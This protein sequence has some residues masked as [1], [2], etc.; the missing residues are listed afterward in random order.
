[1]GKCISRLILNLS[2]LITIREKRHYFE[3]YGRV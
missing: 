3:K 2:N 1:L